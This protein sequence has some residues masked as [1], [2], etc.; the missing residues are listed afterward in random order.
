MCAALDVQPTEIVF[1]SGATEG[2]NMA[3]KGAMQYSDRGRH[4]IT[5]GTEHPSVYECAG[6]A[7]MEVTYLPVDAAGVVDLALTEAVRKDTV[8]VS[9][10]HVNNET[11]AVQ[12]LTEVGR[13]VKDRNSRTRISM[14]YRDLAN[15][16]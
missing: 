2:N 15:C 8:L 1:T 5:T 6:N 10:M 4:I 14:G 13:I 3:I 16:R 12:P 11:G 7:W 9:I